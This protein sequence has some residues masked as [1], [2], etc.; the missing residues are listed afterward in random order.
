MN[1]SEFTFYHQ[2]RTDV[3]IDSCKLTTASVHNLFIRD[4]HLV[5]NLLHH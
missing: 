2:I 1:T 3:A 5:Q 4:L